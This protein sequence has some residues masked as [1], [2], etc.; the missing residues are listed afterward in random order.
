MDRAIF[1]PSSDPSP[2]LQRR[3]PTA[4][5][6][7]QDA[8]KVI[9]I[10]KVQHQALRAG[11]A[12]MVAL[13]CL[14]LLRSPTSL[15]PNTSHD[16]PRVKWTKVRSASGQ[17]VEVPILVAKEKVVKVVRGYQGRVSLPGYPQN[18]TNATLVLGPLRA[19]DTGLYRCE[20]VAGIDDEQDLLPLE[21]TGVVFHYRAASNRYTLSFPA[22]QDACRRSSAVI[23]TPGHLQAAFEDGYDNCDA[24]WLSDH[25]VRYPITLSRPG[26]YGDRNSLPGV[27]SYGLRDPQ[28]RYDVYC[29]ARELKGEVFYVSH[30]RRLTLSG[31]RAH[32]QSQG[33]TLATVGQLY[34][35]WQEGLDQCDPGWLADGSVRYPI[36]TPRKKCGGEEPGVRTLYQFPNRT[37]FPEPSL[38]FDAY[39]YRAH[40]LAPP[41]QL[42]EHPAWAPGAGSQP[43]ELPILSLENIL[44]E[45]G[46]AP[47]PGG[48]PGPDGDDLLVSGDSRDG[49]GQE[50]PTL[51][52]RLLAP[53]HPED[54]QLQ[55]TT[56]TPSGMAQVEEG[57]LLD[58]YQARLGMGAGSGT[59][60]SLADRAETAGIT[61][62]VPDPELEEDQWQNMV[63]QTPRW[64]DST[65]H[66]PPEAT[67]QEPQGPGSTTISEGGSSVP[68][69]L[70]PTQLWVPA[71]ITEVAGPRARE[72]TLSNSSG[73]LG[74]PGPEGFPTSLPEGALGVTGGLGMET[75]D[76]SKPGTTTAAPGSPETTRRG[77]YKGL[78]GRY[79]QKARVAPKR[80]WGS[81]RG[82]TAAPLET[83]AAGNHMENPSVLALGP[84][85]I[86]ET[87]SL[88]NEVDQLNSDV[89]GSEKSG[90]PPSLLTSVSDLEERED[91]EMIRNPALAPEE[92]NR[93]S[94]TQP[95]ERPVTSVQEPRAF[96]VPTQ[97][98]TSSANTD[99]WAASLSPDAPL[100]VATLDQAGG[101]LL[102]RLRDTGTPRQTDSP[103]SQ[104]ATRYPLPTSSGVLT[105]RA[106]SSSRQWVQGEDSEVSS[107][108]A[109]V[110][111]EVDVPVLA[112]LRAPK[113]FPLSSLS[114]TPGTSLPQDFTPPSR[115]TPGASL[116][117][118]Q[119]EPS[120]IAIFPEDPTAS[121]TQHVNWSSTGT[122]DPGW[123]R[124]GQERI[125]EESPTPPAPLTMDRREES[126]TEI[127][128]PYRG[129]E[130]RQVGQDQDPDPPSLLSETETTVP[131]ATSWQGTGVALA[132][133]TA[134]VPQ[135]ETPSTILLASHPMNRVGG[136]LDSLPPIRITA[137]PSTTP[138]YLATEATEEAEV[139]MEEKEEVE[140]EEEGPGFHTVATS[141]AYAV[142]SQT[143]ASST[144]QSGPDEPSPGH[145]TS[146]NP[147]E[148]ESAPWRPQ[149]ESR[150]EGLLESFWATP[151]PTQA[152]SLA[153]L[154]AQ[155]GGPSGEPVLAPEPLNSWTPKSLS[156][157][158]PE[159]SG[160]RVLQGTPTS[161]PEQDMDDASGEGRRELPSPLGLP[162][163]HPTTNGLLSSSEETLR[164]SEAL[165]ELPETLLSLQPGLGEGG[166]PTGPEGKTLPEEGSEEPTTDEGSYSLGPEGASPEEAERGPVTDSGGLALGEEA[167]SGPEDRM[168]PMAEDLEIPSWTLESNLSTES[169]PD[170]CKNNPCLHGGTCQPNGTVYS[171]NCGQGFTG[172]N[173]EIDIDDCLSGPC[174][175]GGTCIDEINSFVCLCLPSYGGSVCEK[176]TEGCD[177]NWHKFQGHCYRYFA[178]RRAW[179][180]AE[181]DCRRRAGHLTSIHSPEEHGF[182]NSFGHENTWIGLNDR[183]VE[184]DFQWTDNTGLQYENW[185]EN[186]P[187]NFFAG[188][189]DCVVTVAHESGRWN[190]VPCNYNL[191]YICKKGTV[192]CGLPP[193]VENAFPLGSRKDKYSIHSTVRY[194]CEEGFLQHHL[195]TIK[196]HSNGK[197]DRPKIVCTKPRRSHR[198]RRHHRHHHP[199]H[200]H[201]HHKSRKERRKHKKHPKLDWE[202]EE[203]ESNFC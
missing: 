60:A 98:P 102:W 73:G 56:A 3:D 203:E 45:H 77:R 91:P 41:T 191:P 78:N 200:Q 31:A 148:P 22:A 130:A 119:G 14:F 114:P 127:G 74:S 64:R 50:H 156:P 182:I 194:Q 38:K 35:A 71:A 136:D 82:S 129:Q 173:C 159:E 28:E 201:H 76:P 39:C 66:P 124:S 172:E 158:G 141:S 174:Q 43:E 12:E 197:W 166:E 23:A 135:E 137:D 104:Y 145:L 176:D 36:Q 140:E 189:E 164:P 160:G 88:S 165:P 7:S 63:D 61:S 67:S 58:P 122:Q 69:G 17:K 193:A 40:Y 169:W 6:G 178:H 87:S 183:I 168:L 15:G 153:G 84:P 32:C 48:L 185:R 202:E 81:G 186:Q 57:H 175:N 79:F 179:E 154:P 188:G 187:D 199:H 128:S 25:T 131:G 108:E 195:P 44:Q 10:N 27:R 150:T 85:S 4:A 162:A 151:D 192:L 80:K 133:T 113:P 116:Q 29:F 139:E 142:Q 30:P 34:L 196:C 5:L 65:L 95:E 112:M 9:H 118:P 26:C 13:P 123:G 37:G 106:E 125:G 121:Q 99:S 1:Q 177:H 155:E 107:G 55:P 109:R 115:M 100:T 16:P 198:T 134:S 171:C 126:V 101:G 68:K 138:G 83:K 2:C 94:L 163:P 75:V 19:S 59:P 120:E 90:S 21:V 132:G 53:P 103:P 190:D 143:P 11:L 96:P 18:R 20:V 72:S 52:P 51:K 111:K 157:N 144:S 110:S 97:E 92:G 70:G 184:R 42:P 152:N 33:A 86:P 89:P 147:L 46:P 181:R 93:P 149:P 62:L 167:G 49:T 146:R 117:E 170:P 161:I 105:G 54:E 24:G 47:S 8:G 180:D